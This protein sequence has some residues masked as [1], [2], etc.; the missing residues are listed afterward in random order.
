MATVATEADIYDLIDEHEG[1]KML[2]AQAQKYLQMSGA[3]FVLRYEAGEIPVPD[4]SEVVR[5]SMLLPFIKQSAN[6]R[7]NTI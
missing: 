5:L 7:K 2:D 4:R 1:L 6:G 3:E